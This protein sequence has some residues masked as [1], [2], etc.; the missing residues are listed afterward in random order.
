MHDSW[1]GSDFTNDDLV[2]ASS[3]VHDYTHALIPAP[4]DSVYRIELKPRPGAPV[5][6]GRIVADVRKKDYMPVRQAFYDHK[7]RLKKEMLFSE[8][9]I[10]G[11]RLIPTR[12]IMHT[13][14]RG[15]RTS[16]T[17]MRYL[18]VRFNLR[19]SSGIFSRANLRRGR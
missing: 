2:R 17:E 14:R 7:N 3:I 6:W 1:M 12:F 11:G 5:V 19:L 16:S 18:R 8:F 13:V 10:M 9:R 15:R 4:N